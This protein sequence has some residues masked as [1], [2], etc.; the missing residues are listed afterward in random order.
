VVGEPARFYA[1]LDDPAAIQKVYLGWYYLRNDTKEGWHKA[2]DLFG[3]VARSHPDQPYGSVL[4]GFALWLGAT[5]GWAADTDA[6]L[7]RAVDL[8]REGAAAGDPTGMA[9]AVEAAVL[10]SRGAVDEALAKLDHLDIVRPTCDITYGLQGSLRRYLGQWERAVE[11]LDV[12]M[13]LTGI[14]KPWYPTVKAASLFVG[15]RLDEAASL[16]EEVL[17]HQPNNLE[18]LLVLAAAQMELGLER[19]A[20]GTADLI[21]QRLPA[22]DV[23]DWLDKTP[24]Q[25]R[26]IVDR[27]K[28]DLMSAGAIAGG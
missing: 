18:A 28:D 2:L 17:D 3:E 5:N 10:M 22:V 7:T 14:N 8:A 21:K 1:E 15:G 19:R 4:S 25:R 16:A 11:L 27:W 9:Q 6:A 12:A 13:R 24:Y 26:D 20:R 23:E